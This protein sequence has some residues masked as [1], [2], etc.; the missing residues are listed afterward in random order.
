MVCSE[1][2]FPL[3]LMEWLLATDPT[4]V[5]SLILRITLGIVFL[6]HGLQ[7]V[8]GWFGGNGFQKTIRGLGSMG[9]PSPIAFLIILGES[10]GSL[11]LILGLL[12]R[13]GAFGILCIMLGALF[14]VHGKMGFFMNW[15]GNKEG[16]GCEYHLLAIGIAVVLLING[17]GAYALDSWL[18]A[19]FL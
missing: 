16:E 9:I 3:S 11:G 10:L 7:K 12:T 8:F 13:I 1:Q 2:Y 19:A 6:P 4:D 15:H 5:T 18:A 14:M 17:G